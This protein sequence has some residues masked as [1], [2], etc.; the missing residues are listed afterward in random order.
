[1]NIVQTAEEEYGSVVIA[2][3]QLKAVVIDFAAEFVAAKSKFLAQVTKEAEKHNIDAVNAWHW[4]LAQTAFDVDPE[5]VE[6]NDEEES[7]DGDFIG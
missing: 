7:E 4:A 3:L 2:K 1:M 6:Y 5:F